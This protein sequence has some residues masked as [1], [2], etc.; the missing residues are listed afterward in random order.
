MTTQHNAAAT[1]AGLTGQR[2]DQLALT[3]STR[4]LTFY[5]TSQAMGFPV[6]MLPVLFAIGRLAGWLAQWQEGRRDAEQRIASSDLCRRGAQT[7]S[8]R[9]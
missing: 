3:S 9:G 4:M 7:S 6:E 2:H 1:A 8:P 5:F